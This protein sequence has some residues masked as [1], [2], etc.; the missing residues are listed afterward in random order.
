MTCDMKI[1]SVWDFPGGPVVKTPHSQC[2]MRSL[3][4]E[5]RS[6]MPHGLTK[7]QSTLLMFKPHPPYTHSKKQYIHYVKAQT[8][9]S[10]QWH[11]W[12]F[13]LSDS[14]LWVAVLLMV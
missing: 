12:H 5:L 2:R 4:K 8:R 3:I 13:G 11:H 6:Y 14:S 9:G 10:Q 1:S 7:R